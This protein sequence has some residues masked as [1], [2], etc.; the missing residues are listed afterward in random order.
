MRQFCVLR[1]FE[2]EP[3]YQGTYIGWIDAALSDEG[4]RNARVMGDRLREM[5]WEFD[6][7]FSS[8]LQRCVRS[9]EMMGFDLEQVTQLPELREK[10][11]GRSEG[12][13]FEEIQQC[14]GVQYVDFSGWIEAIG[15]ESVEEFSMRVNKVFVEKIFAVPEKS[16]LV[17]AHAGVMHMIQSILSQESIE[18]VFENR[19]EYGDALF[20]CEDD[21]E[22]TVNRVRLMSKGECFFGMMRDELE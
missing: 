7:V 11:F 9:L 20:V 18:R 12:M 6:A 22:F 16:V 17:M 3:R 13:S 10:S 21:G 5:G 4:K 1:H 15:G 2:V 8:D 19:L 14:Y